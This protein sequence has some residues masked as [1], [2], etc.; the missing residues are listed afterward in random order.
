MSSM[1]STTLEFVVG[2]VVGSASLLILSTTE[3]GEILGK[4]DLKDT[5]LSCG[6]CMIRAAAPA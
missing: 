1:V 2:I 3:T 5:R 4:G 6:S